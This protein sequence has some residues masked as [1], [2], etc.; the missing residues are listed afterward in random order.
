MKLSIHPE[1]NTLIHTLQEQ[2]YEAFVVGGCVRNALLGLHPHD[3]R[4]R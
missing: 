2:G 1:A 4:M 3:S